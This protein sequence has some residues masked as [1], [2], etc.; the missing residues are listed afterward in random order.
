MMRWTHFALQASQ[1]LNQQSTLCEERAREPVAQLVSTWKLICSVQLS[2]FVCQGWLFLLLTHFN[3]SRQR[4]FT[5]DLSQLERR[6][7]GKDEYHLL[8]LFSFSPQKQHCPAMHYEYMSTE[9]SCGVTGG[10]EGCERPWDGSTYCLALENMTIIT[11]D[12]GR[13]KD[14][15]RD[16]KII[17]LSYSRFKCSLSF[18]LS[19]SV[20]STVNPLL[21]FTWIDGQ[22]NCKSYCECSFE[23]SRTHIALEFRVK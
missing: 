9:H 20:L 14:V 21:I 4:N 13:W 15:R 18:S 5:C 16:R 6:G 23:C 12:V 17:K 10:C 7:G 11:G 22:F 8:L 19:L 3:W 2:P 1:D